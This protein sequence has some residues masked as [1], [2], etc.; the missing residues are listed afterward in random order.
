MPETIT[1]YSLDKFAYNISNKFAKNNCYLTP[2]HI[3]ILN[4]FVTFAILYSFYYRYSME[5]ILLLIFI[6]CF[7]DIL[8]GS[9]ARMC[10]KGSKFGH[11]L[12]TLGDITARFLLLLLIFYVILIEKQNINKQNIFQ[13]LYQIWNKHTI[14]LKIIIIVIIFLLFYHIYLF[15]LFIS[16]KDY[17]YYSYLSDHTIILG[18]IIGYLTRKYL[19]T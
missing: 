13:Q 4:M 14:I 2:N 17:E 18:L 15:Y 12:D 1:K 10:N 19:I 8:D 7:L 9:V 6:R 5:S 11:K 16:E 3:T